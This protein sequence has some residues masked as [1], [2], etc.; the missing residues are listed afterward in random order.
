M[1]LLGGENLNVPIMPGATNLSGS[2]FDMLGMTQP[3]SGV[4]HNPIDPIG[5]SNVEYQQVQNLV[6]PSRSRNVQYK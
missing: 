3:S 1:P 2:K 6:V 4:I 5:S